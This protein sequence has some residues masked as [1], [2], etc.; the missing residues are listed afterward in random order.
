MNKKKDV[1]GF[2]HAISGIVNA[3]IAERNLKIHGGIAIIVLG[4][5]YVFR[6]SKQE[7]LILILTV[8]FVIVAELV[9][10]AIE[11]VVDLICEDILKD[12]LKQS[13]YSQRAKLAKDVGAG[14]VL[15]AAIIAVIIGIIL[16]APKILG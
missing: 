16:F 3:F 7:Y 2:R 9:N 8:G 1:I 6:F 15:F 5:A 13:G 14:A 12:Q 4:L 11:A 10:T